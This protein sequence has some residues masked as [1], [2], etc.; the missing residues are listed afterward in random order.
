MERVFLEGGNF[1]LRSLLRNM[2]IVLEPPKN[3]GNFYMNKI[4]D[5]NVLFLVSWLL[6]F[7]V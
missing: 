1:Y 2:A 4:E 6:S 5:E 3:L 7:P